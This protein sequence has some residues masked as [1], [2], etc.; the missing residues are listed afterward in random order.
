MV[1]PLKSVLGRV[2]LSVPAVLAAIDVDTN[3]EDSIRKAAALVAED[4]MSFYDGD[5]PGKIPGI[6]PG[7]PP[8]GDYYWWSGGLLWNTLIDY[9][10]VTGETKYVDTTVKGLE[11]QLG[12]DGDFAPANWTVTTGNDDQGIWANAALAAAMSGLPAPSVKGTV[13]WLSPARKVVDEMTLR[14][15]DNGTTQ[16]ALRWQFMTFNNGYNYINS[17][18]NAAYFTLA[19]GLAH[20]TKNDTLAKQAASTYEVLT[21]LGLIDAKFNIYDG[22]HT[23]DD[24]KTIN[25]LQVSENAGLLLTG[26][27]YMLNQ[28][29]GDET[30]KKRVDGLLDQT[31]KIFF[32]DGVASEVSCET[33]SYNCPG[34][35][36]QYKGM[37]HRG[38]GQTMRLAPYTK[39]K[40]LPVLKTS[41]A[42]AVK[43]C[44]GGTNQ[45]L[46]SSYWGG[47]DDKEAARKDAAAAQ[48]DVLNALNS[49]LMASDNAK[50]T[51]GNGST[52]GGNE[53][54]SSAAAGG[55]KDGNKD[56]PGSMGSTAAV[57][58]AM[59]L[60]GLF[61]NVIALF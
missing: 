5:K 1:R 28:T 54:G 46:C 9:G 3:N 10:S 59:L 43:T 7:P 12:Q 23:T 56:T 22:C 52:D 34:D 4:L 27:A 60:G 37:L 18:S 8:D 32:P 30:W 6:L 21:K 50:S 13:D 48:M 39:S 40:I 2:L 42:A 35:M 11:W 49:V 14:R 33:R 16:G 51:G 31:L 29:G 53:Q 44:T 57:S 25:R 26:A 47:G 24:C 15:I 19:A 36:Q 38:L 17:A 20:Q 61:F 58:T 45:R 55:T 41:A